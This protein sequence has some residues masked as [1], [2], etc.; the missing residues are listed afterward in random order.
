MNP[1]LRKERIG[2]T[3]AARVLNVSV[4]E[5]KEAVQKQQLLRG[6]RVPDPVARGQGSSGTQVSFH[7]GDVMDLAEAL[8]RDR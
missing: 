5:L 6:H 2:I 7:L 4:S 1:A 8:D 3:H